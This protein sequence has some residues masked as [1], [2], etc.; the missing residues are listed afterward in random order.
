M[1]AAAAAADTAKCL[2]LGDQ[3]MLEKK[4]VCRREEVEEDVAWLSL[5]SWAAEYPVKGIGIR[6]Q[7][8]GGIAK[9]EIL[10]RKLVAWK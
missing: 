10:S 4:S 5:K 7:K 3:N 1:A 9:D 2:F 8:M 6:R